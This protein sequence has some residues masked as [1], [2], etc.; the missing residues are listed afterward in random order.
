[1]VVVALAIVAAVV[2]VLERV[3]GFDNG[4]PA[5]LLAVVAVAVLRGTGPAIATA[6]GAFLVYDFLFIEPYYT[7]TVS[8]PGEWLNLA[9]PPGRRHRRRAAGRPRA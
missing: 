1:M 2:A 3:A 8:D 7:L 9:T 5:F 6:V 4:S